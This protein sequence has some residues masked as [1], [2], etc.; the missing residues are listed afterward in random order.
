[1][2]DGSGL[3]DFDV[4]TVRFGLERELAES[5]RG[6]I[7]NFEARR[8]SLVPSDP[9]R[10]RRRL[11]ADALR[12]TES[13]APAAYARAHEARDAL[14][15]EGTLELYQAASRPNATLHLVESP[16]LLEVQSRLLSLLDDAAA[17]ALFGHELGRYLAHG[18]WTE[19][20]ATLYVAAVLAERSLLEPEQAEAARRGVMA[21][22][23]TADRVGL[24]A[25][26]D[27]HA[28]IR[29]EMIATTGLSG[30]TLT[31]DTEA[32][33]EACKQRMAE[34]AEERPANETPYGLRTWALWKF[35]QSDVWGGIIGATGGRPLAEIDAE[36]AAVL[37]GPGLLRIEDDRA[38]LPP[39]VYECALACAVLVG[40]ADGDLSPQE[41][42][43][44]EDAF[45]PHVPSWSEFLEPEVAH[46]R[47]YETG[48]LVRAGGV[49]LAR[50]LFLLLSHVI[51]ADDVV[52]GREIQMV[53]S[54]G[55]ALGFADEFRSWLQPAVAAMGVELEEQGDAPSSIPL[56]ARRAEVRDALAALCVAVQRT[57][58][59]AISPR[60]LLRLMGAEEDDR[61]ALEGIAG[62]LEQREIDVAP[63]LQSVRFDDLVTLSARTSVA[64]PPADP[65]A[66]IPADRKALIAAV[67]RLRDELISGDGRSPSVRLRKTEGSRRVFDLFRLEDIRKGTPERALA[68]LQAGER[69]VLVTPDDAGRHDAARD[70]TEDLRQLDRLA[71]DQREET[72]ANDLFVGYPVLLGSVGVAEDPGAGYAVRGPLVLVPVDLERDGRGARGFTIKPR[73]QEPMANQSL[74]R[75]LFNKAGLALP[76]ELS[77]EFDALAGDP[78]KGVPA[79]IDRLR[80]VGVSVAVEGTT[81]GRFRG[82]NEQLDGDQRFLAV[83]EC[84]LLGLFPQSSSE[85]LQDYDAL[86]RDLEA[87]QTPLP[88][89]L[90]AGFGLLPAALQTDPPPPIPEHAPGWPVLPS[91]PSQRAV[92]EACAKNLV[93]VVDGPPGTGK[94]QLIVNLVAD[95][96]R[97]GAKVAVVAEK[98]AALDVVQQRLAGCG[99]EDSLALVHDVGDDRKALFAKIAGRLKDFKPRRAN[100]MRMDVLRQDHA[101][102]AETLETRRTTLA[103]VPEGVGLSVG[104]LL[105][106]AAGGDA[107]LQAGSLV[108]LGRDA[109]ARLLELVER[110]HPLADVWDPHGWWRLQGDRAG[111]ADMGDEDF[112]ALS[113][114]LTEACAEAASSRAVRMDRPVPIATLRAGAPGLAAVADLLAKS[115][116]G[117]AALVCAVW[118]GA[119][120]DIDALAGAWT[121]TATALQTWSAPLA[122]ADDAFARGVAVLRSFAGNFFRIVSPLWWRT[123]GEVRAALPTVWPERAADGFSAGFL[124]ELQGRID[125]GKTWA[126]TQAAFA[127]MGH[128]Q[129]T[130]SNAEQ[131]KAAIALL[132]ACQASVSIVQ[133][134][135][136]TLDALGMPAPTTAADLEALRTTLAHRQAQLAADD[137]IRARLATVI[138]RFG[139]AQTMEAEQ[140]D[141]FATRLRADGHRLRDADGWLAQ[142][143]EVHPDARSV[144]DNLL[145]VAEGQSAEEWREVLARAWS[146]AHLTRQEAFLPALADLGTTAQGQRAVDAMDKLATLEEEIADHEVE[147]ICAK[148]DEA[149][150]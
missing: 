107:L 90:S 147:A 112:A 124:G 98:R 35:A 45:S 12:L 18:P 93:T 113:R 72:G 53:L 41:L 97:R 86:L 55:E 99:L 135:Q 144:L 28:A 106:L 143:D 102:A 111:L 80:D 4:E 54:I 66:D 9:G 33:L 128:P 49:D 116:G 146:Q 25:C 142:L 87:G 62:F 148:L 19:I 117:D 122:P 138:P 95:A 100:A 11:L 7:P 63:P 60:R 75:L 129:L 110:V 140:L 150:L 38:E 96:M 42:A 145:G 69:A 46:E 139:W 119:A 3:R 8:K 78:A 17:R 123:R 50:R 16:I 76:D 1:M 40:G 22:A 57:R 21:R 52:D 24:I 15:I 127:A 120:P 37:H 115:E 118:T 92:A 130:P 83:E 51:G 34:A 48:G 82:R 43:A 74:L 30:D 56:P 88:T 58:Q 108:D 36:I 89:L 68:L 47:F 20:G 101:R 85:L 91:D 73:D 149:K 132:Q 26:R 23:I 131:A 70:C 114:A 29:L 136:S 39:F 84:A 32:Y 6:S 141:D 104:Q 125:A 13:M 71:R 137:R 134:H 61:K 77:R 79:L 14:G 59:T 67:S 126:Q 64:P 103:S 109:L 121:N 81:L 10:I 65:D 94:S 2:T 105:A 44:I 133:Q 5:L 27:L 31:W